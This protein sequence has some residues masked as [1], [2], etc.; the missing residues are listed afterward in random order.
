MNY[1]ITNSSQSNDTLTTSIEFAHKDVV[2]FVDVAHFRPKSF[3]EIEASI[4]NRISSEISKITATEVVS[5][6]S[7]PIDVDKSIE[8]IISSNAVVNPLAG[9]TVTELKDQITILSNE[10]NVIMDLKADLDTQLVD[11]SNKYDLLIEELAKRV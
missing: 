3:D 7:V 8:Y 1:K 5:T 11:N 4:I 6:I 2:Y 9:S 10:Y